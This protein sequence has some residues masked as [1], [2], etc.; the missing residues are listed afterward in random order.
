VAKEKKR[1]KKRQRMMAA[2][3]AAEASA[4]SRESKEEEMTVSKGKGL[5]RV[6]SPRPN[7]EDSVKTSSKP[8]KTQANEDASPGD[9]TNETRPRKEKKSASAKRG[10]PVAMDS[11]E[12]QALCGNSAVEATA[13][14]RGRGRPR[15][16]Q[17]KE[18]AI[19]ATPD[20]TNPTNPPKTTESENLEWVQCEKCLKWRKLPPHIAADDLP[21]VWTC[22]M[23][24]W[25]PHAASCDSPE[26]KA[27]GLQDIPSSGS[28]SGKLS[29]RNLIFGSTGRKANRPISERTRAAESL[30]SVQFDEEDAP[31]KV[32]YSESSAFVSRSKPTML[33]D[34][35]DRMSVLEMMGHSQLWQELRGAA[36]PLIYKSSDEFL[37]SNTSLSAYSYEHL[38]A[39]IQA[40]MKDL[41][42]M[43][44]ESGTM[45]GDDIVGRAK[46][47][48]QGSL[49]DPFYK[50][51]PLCTM[52]VVVT[53][54]YDLVKEGK[55]D[56]VK[57]IGNSWSMNDW[58]PHYRR[59]RK[60]L[61]PPP[62]SS[63]ENEGNEPSQ[64]A[65]MHSRCMKI[66]K[67]WKRN[68]SY[69]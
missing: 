37:K 22:D 29:Y 61:P 20:E 24:D 55:V 33:V 48:E 31:S 39:D 49:P 64:G 1:S 57:G 67:P 51:L 60:L 47:V 30:Y 34:E 66:A 68:G 32:L 36:Q 15:R 6:R 50:I 2:A 45:S 42:L 69:C 46:S 53:T 62:Q 41:L 21:D 54:L 18:I 17:T 23:N 63:V 9:G 19:T 16:I 40:S 58:K 14:P 59:A 8:K 27:D 28:N 25:N 3:A 44:L 35:N 56:C 10:R 38:P 11:V 5:D 43:V 52:N 12:K 26:D 7:R 65:R 13:K 4:Q